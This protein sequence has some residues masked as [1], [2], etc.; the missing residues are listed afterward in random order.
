MRSTGLER[1]ITILHS[2]L[3][4]YLSLWRTEPEENSP[5]QLSHIRCQNPKQLGFEF[6]GS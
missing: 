2:S 5:L 4:R 6:A 1:T 3:R